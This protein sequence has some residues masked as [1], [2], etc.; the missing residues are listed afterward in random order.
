MIFFLS[1]MKNVDGST[2]GLGCLWDLLAKVNMSQYCNQITY[3]WWS[4]VTNL[5][6]SHTE[7]KQ[8]MHQEIAWAFFSVGMKT[9]VGQMGLVGFFGLILPVLDFGIYTIQRDRSEWDYK[10]FP[11]IIKLISISSSWSRSPNDCGNNALWCGLGLLSE[12]FL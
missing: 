2:E 5:I 12:L 7:K 8:R 4:K 9:H 6:L 3:L 1:D 11:G 10:D